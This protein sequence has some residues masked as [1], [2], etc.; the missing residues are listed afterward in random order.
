[1]ARCVEAALADSDAPALRR[2]ITAVRVVWGVWPYADPGRLVAERIGVPGA[3]T[4]L[5][6]MGGNQVYDLV[7]DTAAR[8]Q[9]GDLDVA[10]VCAAETLRTRRADRARG[11]TH[12]VRARGRRCRARRDVRRRQADEHGGRAG[13]R[14]RRRGQLLRDGRDRDPAPQSAK[15]SRPTGIGSLPCGRRPARSRSDNP[16]AWIR[17]PVAGRRDRHRVAIQPSHRVAVSEADDGQP[18]TSTRAAQW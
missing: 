7:N 17:R 18:R 14:P 6:A 15:P 8:I 4:T 12:A 16:D 5:T 10:V 3:R 2:S 11:H 9:R 1:M 13:D